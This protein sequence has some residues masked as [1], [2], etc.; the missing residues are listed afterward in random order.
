ML[1]HAVIQ[2]AASEP[3][4]LLAQ[5]EW[6]ED[7]MLVAVGPWTLHALVRGTS[8]WERVFYIIRQ[9]ANQMKCGD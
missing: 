3:K 5:S 4:L 7:V 1:P 6:C 2:T 9:L 8:Q